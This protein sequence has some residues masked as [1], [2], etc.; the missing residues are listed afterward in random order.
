[1][2]VVSSWLL[3]VYEIHVCYLFQ[4]FFFFFLCSLLD[5]MLHL[6]FF[7]YRCVI[8]DQFNHV[9]FDCMLFVYDYPWSQKRG[10]W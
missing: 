6:L 7:C 8:I 10:G 3:K 5:F 4:F 1:M 2:G 9:I